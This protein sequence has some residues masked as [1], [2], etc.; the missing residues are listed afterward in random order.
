MYNIYIYIYKYVY[1]KLSTS[2]GIRIGSCVHTE[3][4]STGVYVHMFSM[5]I[6]T[7]VGQNIS[8]K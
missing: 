1:T 8:I 2:V 6:R 5:Y 4:I 7:Y 3:Y